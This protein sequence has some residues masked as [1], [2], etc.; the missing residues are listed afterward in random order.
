MVQ[1]ILCYCDL[2]HSTAGVV[3]VR[4]TDHGSKK[5]TSVVYKDLVQ[6]LVEVDSKFTVATDVTRERLDQELSTCRQLRNTTEKVAIPGLVEL[7][8]PESQNL[9]FPALRTGL[10]TDRQYYS[11]SN[12]ARWLVDSIVYRLETCRGVDAKV[13]AGAAGAGAVGLAA[14]YCEGHGGKR[15]F[16]AAPQ[17]EIG[18]GLGAALA[19]GKKVTRRNGLA[20]DKAWVLERLGR[21]GSQELPQT[22]ASESFPLLAPWPCKVPE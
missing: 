5:K 16:T 20:D 13:A 1:N 3:T 18:V 10:I 22:D 15:W 8:S 21:R 17:A 19:V 2:I 9:F 6:E 14:S 12:D 11:L 7:Y 4:K